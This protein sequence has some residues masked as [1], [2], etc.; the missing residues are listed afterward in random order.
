MVFLSFLVNPCKWHKLWITFVSKK[1]V[2]AGFCF[3]VKN[4]A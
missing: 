2:I 3:P 1:P 4:G